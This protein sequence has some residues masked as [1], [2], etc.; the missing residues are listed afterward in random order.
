MYNV[1]IKWFL[2]IVI[3]SYKFVVEKIYESVLNDIVLEKF[4][5]LVKEVKVV[6][7]INFWMF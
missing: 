6:V 7:S 4:K 5:L 2:D 3:I 1:F